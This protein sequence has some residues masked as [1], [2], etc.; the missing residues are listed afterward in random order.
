[1]TTISTISLLA[2]DS[3]S[4]TLSSFSQ[5]KVLLFAYPKDNT[6]GCSIEN[7]EFSKLLPDFEKL[8]VKVVGISADSVKSHQ[9]FC[10]KLSLELTLLSDPEK[11]LLNELGAI[12][13]KSMFGKKYMGIE[14]STYLIK[15]KIGKVLKTWNKVSPAGHAKQVLEEIKNS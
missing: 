10:D 14:R 9:S 15:T 13:E 12:V 1:M 5:D 6:P 11:I 2:Q 7:A 8:G 3:N 4:Y